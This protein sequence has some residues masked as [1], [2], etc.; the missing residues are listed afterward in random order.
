MPKS[1]VKTIN[2]RSGVEYDILNHNSLGDSGCL[3]MGMMDKKVANR[4]KGLCEFDDITN[5]YSSNFDSHYAGC[6]QKYPNIFKNYTG[7]F[8][9]MYDAARKNG[10]LS[11]PFRKDISKSP[12]KEKD[13][14]NHFKNKA[15]K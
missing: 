11:V 12:D 5:P 7:I 10:N 6:I 4:K 8:S 3:K 13:K 14:E 2:N 1:N 15:K 9:N